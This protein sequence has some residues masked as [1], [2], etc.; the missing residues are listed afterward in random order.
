MMVPWEPLEGRA[1]GLYL[2]VL[3]KY[4]YQAI[5]RQPEPIQPR[6]APM[7]EMEAVGLE[8]Q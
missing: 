8:D 1:A 4:L 3:M 5:S 7:E 2:S 6:Q